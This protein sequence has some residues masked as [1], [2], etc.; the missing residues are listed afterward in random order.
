MTILLVAAVLNPRIFAPA[1]YIPVSPDSLLNEYAGKDADPSRV[2]R[3]V[4]FIFN[5]KVLPA[6]KLM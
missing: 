6:V 5:T 2:R 4:E 3:P 1:L